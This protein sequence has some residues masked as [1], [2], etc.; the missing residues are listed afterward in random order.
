MVETGR[1]ELYRERRLAVVL[2]AISVR[3]KEFLAPA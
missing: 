3:T 1:V 2:I